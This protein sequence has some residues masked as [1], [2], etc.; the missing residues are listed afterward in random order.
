MPAEDSLTVA[1]GFI[2]AYPNA[3]Y[4][5]SREALE[6]F[7][8]AVAELDSE[9]DYRAFAARF[10]VRRNAPDFWAHSDALHAAYLEQAPIAAGLFDYNR[11]ENR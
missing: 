9:E 5:V 6:E 3:F 1:R 10:G 8:Q 2:G 4:R 11:L 7:I